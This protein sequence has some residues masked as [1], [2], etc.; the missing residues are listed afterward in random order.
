MQKLANLLTTSGVTTSWATALCIAAA[1]VAMY[2]LKLHYTR[3]RR[4]SRKPRRRAP[5]RV[6]S[7]R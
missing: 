5:A 7:R 3:E 4:A 2:W 6:R 1:F